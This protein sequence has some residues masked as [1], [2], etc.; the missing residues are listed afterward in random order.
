MSVVAIIQ[1]R[2]GSTRLPGKVL[3]A[4]GGEP[5]LAHVVRRVQRAGSVELTVVA[6]TAGEV[7]EPI[8]KECERLGVAIYRGSELDVLDRFYRVACHFGAEAVVR[9][10]SD[11]PLIDPGVID[12]VVVTFLDWWPDYASNVLRRTYP[13]GL[14]T[15]VVTLEALETAW[16]EA[17][18]PYERVH[19]TPYF[20]KHPERFRL[21]S[22]T[23]EPHSGLDASRYRWTVDTAEDLVLVREIH[24]Q[25]GDGETFG[26]TDVLDLLER[27]PGL[28]DL[29]RSIQQKALDEG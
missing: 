13:R 14:D 10:T 29:N 26:W 7:D 9:I 4:I 21:L 11:C 12:R 3:S 19:V 17:A 22:V 2:M 23:R 5:M 27:N 6:A 25:L 16:H 1:A 20:Y 15:E 24:R 8:V 18:E 28:A